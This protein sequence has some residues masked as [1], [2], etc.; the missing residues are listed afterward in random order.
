[1]ED[2]FSGDSLTQ[3]VVELMVKGYNINAISRKIETP[4]EI[5]VKVW[6]EYCES[7]FKM[8]RDQQF[9]LQLERVENLLVLAHDVVSMQMDHDSI[10]STLQ[11]LKEIDNLQNLALSRREKVQDDI[12]ALNKAQVSILLGVISSIQAFMR[13]QLAT[14][15][16]YEKFQE[17]QSNFNM[18]FNDISQKALEEVK[19]DV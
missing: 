8:P 13:D 12:V 17:L 6:T 2:T 4:Q 19:S 11:V 10:N 14:I 15:D 3:T 1:M 18:V 5:V 9:V 7:K 16:S